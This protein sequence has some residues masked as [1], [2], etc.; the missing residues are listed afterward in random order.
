[1]SEDTD[2]MATPLVS[3][4]VIER[5]AE[6]L[7][8]GGLVAYPTD[9]VYGLAALPADAAAVEKLFAAKERRPEV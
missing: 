3:E 1:V 2:L 9:T 4:A 8:T 7:R 5:A 6:V